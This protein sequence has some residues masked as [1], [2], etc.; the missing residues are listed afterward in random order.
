MGKSDSTTIFC[1]QTTLDKKM[2]HSFNSVEFLKDLARELVDHFSRA[3]KAT[4]PGLVGSARETAVRKKLE[5]ILPPAAAI[6]SGCVIDSYGGT[7]KQQDVVAYEKA[8]CPVF[9]I[10]DDPET[11]FYPCESVIAVGEIKSTLGKTELEDSFQKIRSVKQLQRFSPEPESF[12]MYGSTLAIM[13]AREEQFDQKAKF[14]DQIYGFIL[15]G[16]FGVKPET[17]LNHYRT[18]VSETDPWERPNLLVSLEDGC[19]VYLSAGKWVVSMD[20]SSGTGVAH[21]SI[22]DGNFQYLVTRLDWIVKH[23]RTSQILPFQRYVLEGDG[24]MQILSYL[25]YES[26]T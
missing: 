1:R 26:K 9:S 22:R 11:T 21:T 15:C 16:K 25:E 20:A 23:G 24:R 7:S 13:G 12:R 5:L 8:N 19:I 6:G 2:E 18:L 10:N 17:I 4:T 14:G 3:G